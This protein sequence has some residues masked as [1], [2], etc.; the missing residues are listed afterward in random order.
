M[1]S[2]AYAASGQIIPCDLAALES[3]SFTRPALF[4]VDATPGARTVLSDFFE[5][6][7]GPLAAMPGGLAVEASGQILVTGNAPAGSLLRVDATTGV[8]TI[9]SNFGNPA[10]G[11]LGLSPSGVALEA[12]GQILVIDRDTLTFLGALFRVDP[13]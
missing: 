2:M 10:Q 9:L 5:P 4:R 7:Q 8:R 13:T 3:T 11:P 1:L 6:A 12:S